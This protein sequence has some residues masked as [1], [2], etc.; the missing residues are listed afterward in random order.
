MYR[1][2]DKMQTSF[3]DFN[4]PLGMHMNLKNRW[5]DLA[6][7]IP[8][9]AFEV[10]YAELFPSSTRNVAKPLRMAFG[11]LIIQTKF[12]SLHPATSLGIIL[13]QHL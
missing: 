2:L 4:Q 13:C 8:W 3:F 1:P 9:D 5:I 11:S 7:Q 12:H 6:H 10:K